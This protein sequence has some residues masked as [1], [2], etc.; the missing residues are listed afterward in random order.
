[1]PNLRCGVAVVAMLAAGCAR[2]DVRT[3]TLQTDAP[4]NAHVTLASE[5]A[6]V[7]A[8]WA[9]STGGK[10]ADIYFAASRDRGRRFSAPVRVNPFTNEAIV[11]GEQPPRVVVKGTNVSVLWV[12]KPEGRTAIRVADSNDFGK[13]FSEARTITP[14]GI[15]G[16]R[17]WESAALAD[18]GSIHVAWLDG[19]SAVSH[20]EEHQHHPGAA[21]PRQDVFHATLAGMQ[22]VAETRVAANVCFCCKTAVATRGRDVYVAWRHLFD[23]GVRDIAIAHSADAGQTFSGPVRVSADNWKIDA[24]PDDGPA[25]AF[26]TH[27]ALHIV[28]PTLARDGGADRMA[29]F[30]AMS[31]DGGATFT[32]RERVN[33]EAKANA[34]HPR[35]ATRGD[36]SAAIVWDEMSDGTRRVVARLW[37]GTLAADVLVVEDAKTSSYPAAV[38]TDQGY[39]AAWT[40]HQD[41]RSRVVVR[42]IW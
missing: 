7:V 33:A 8:V 19:R 6:T 10:A 21:A 32:P 13:T 3:T 25:M 1:M 38:G 11:S 20:G 40:E 4:T 30:H 16:A 23:G 17:G 26:D 35:I 14:A 34:S 9:A 42:S 28:W 29:I 5:G 37:N 2:F 24:C 22:P 31:T 15:S 27:G 18:D 39:V 12:A 41:E 36:G